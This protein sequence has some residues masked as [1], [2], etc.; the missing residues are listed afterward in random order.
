LYGKK[1]TRQWIFLA[2]LGDT[3]ISVHPG[4]RRQVLLLLWF[5]HELHGPG[6]TGGNTQTASYTAGKAYGCELAN[7][8]N[9]IHLAAL[10]TGL[11]SRAFIFVHLR[12]IIT[13]HQFSRL[14]M[15]FQRPENTATI[16][17]TTAHAAYFL[18]VKRLHDQPGFI[19]VADNLLG[20]GF[21]NIAAHSVFHIVLG[22][23]TERK[24]IFKRFVTFFSG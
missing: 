15:H 5:L 24:A 17:A 14:G 19:I 1:S 13:L 7:D 8:F 6:W 12:K 23:G 10:Q 9:G 18:G 2:F 11:A 20:F 3:D 16:T 22:M 4:F 21:G